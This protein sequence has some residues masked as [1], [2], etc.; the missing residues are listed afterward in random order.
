MTLKMRGRYIKSALFVAASLFTTQQG[1]AGDGPGQDEPFMVGE[2]LEEAGYTKCD[3][4][5]VAASRGADDWTV[6]LESA[7]Q[8]AEG[9]IL[10]EKERP[11][12]GYKDNVDAA[13][14]ASTDARG[15]TQEVCTQ[16]LSDIP[17]W[18]VPFE[19]IVSHIPEGYSLCDAEVYAV[20]H[21]SSLAWATKLM[22]DKV[23]HDNNKAAVD[24]ALESAFS[25]ELDAGIESC[26]PQ[27]DPGEIDGELELQSVE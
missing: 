9:K 11:G 20:Y 13:I 6:T 24:S 27:V 1:L 19:T 3:I 14:K 7:R 21:D 15:S 22:E 4:A 12:V 23:V 16:L 18:E 2:V 8:W 26:I 25:D 10:S 5:H 17:T